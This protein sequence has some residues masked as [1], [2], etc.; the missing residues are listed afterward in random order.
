MDLTSIDHIMRPKHVLLALTLTVLVSG[1]GSGTNVVQSWRDPDVTVEVGSIKKML[2]IALLR[3]EATRRMAE[4]EIVSQLPGRAVS[5]YLYLGPLPTELEM[6]PFME[7]LRTD[8]FDGL[9]I[10]RLAEVETQQ[11]YVPGSYPAYYGSP[12]GYYGYSYPMYASP[13]YVQTDQYYR[14]ETNFYSVATEKLVWSGVTSSFNPTSLTGT[15]DDIVKA[16][17]EKM[18][19][20]GFLARPPSSK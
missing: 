15:L 10:M 16:I 14:V 2:V 20:E 17:R 7:R 3:D 11:T 12:Y 19:F 9:M 1:C 6:E 18:E 4:D 5:S 13:G 8:G